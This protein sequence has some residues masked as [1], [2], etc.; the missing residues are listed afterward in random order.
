[1]D[2]SIHSGLWK[3][4]SPPRGAEAREMEALSIPP[5][6]L[7][8]KERE[9]FKHKFWVEGGAAS[10]WFTTDEWHFGPL[11]RTTQQRIGLTPVARFLRQF[12]KPQKCIWHFHSFT[13]LLICMFC[14]YGELFEYLNFR[15]KN[16]DA[17]MPILGANIWKK[18]DKSRFARTCFKIDKI[19]K[20]CRI[21]IIGFVRLR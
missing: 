21:C 19:W 6:E 10:T 3:S 13:K 9:K 7:A 17:S 18:N 20:M 14:I 8:T 2:C 12:S 11:K 16:L 1:M 4:S 15:A 5:R